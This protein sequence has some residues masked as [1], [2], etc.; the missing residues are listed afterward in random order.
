MSIKFKRQFLEDS[1]IFMLTENKSE[2]LYRHFNIVS[3]KRVI[4]FGCGTG[5]FS[6]QM[7]KF[8]NNNGTIIGLDI[9]KELVIAAKEIA[10]QNHNDNIKFLTGDARYTA[11]SDEV[12]DIS[13]CH[14]FLSRI[15][16]SQVL[17]VLKEMYRVTEP[18]GYVAAVEPCL[19]AMRAYYDNDL[20]LSDLLT[21]IRSVKSKAQKILY[22]I[23]ENI[24]MKLYELFEDIELTSIKTEIIL[25]PWWTPPT[26][27]SGEMNDELKAWYSRRLSSLENPHD[28]N[29]TEKYGK[30]EDA[31][32][33][34]RY[35]THKNKSDKK[36]WEIY[37]KNGISE[38]E[39]LE[40]RKLR[41][42]YLQTILNSTSK[43]MY[44]ND[45]EFIPVFAVVGHKN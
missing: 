18:G 34:L 26:F 43:E 1:R 20:R 8:I 45:F 28:R 38:H 23:N 42:N 13:T 10:K 11:I 3:K 32:V 6:R 37:R 27:K 7:A 9:N 22:D 5:Y 16:E 25:L 33:G 17:E 29:V 40:C 44:V 39:L 2:Y 15:P 4:D 21:R 31:A 19:G 24:G 30:I 12:F 14:F 35:T 36:L 41:I